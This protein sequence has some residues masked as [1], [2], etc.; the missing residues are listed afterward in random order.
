[1]PV[2]TISSR[3]SPEAYDSPSFFFHDA[4]PPSVIVGL[5][6]GMVNFVNAC[7]R[8]DI[9][10]PEVS[11]PRN[12]SKATKKCSCEAYSEIIFWILASFSLCGGRRS[13]PK[14]CERIGRKN[15]GHSGVL[16]TPD[17][18]TLSWPANQS[19]IQAINWY[20]YGQHWCNPCIPYR[21]A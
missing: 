17:V 5:I 9:C 4:I 19:N 10:T 16:T 6:A 7:L 2:P 15:V 13:D 1:M 20:I 21:M 3:T 8:A 12:V 11:K 14:S 18:F